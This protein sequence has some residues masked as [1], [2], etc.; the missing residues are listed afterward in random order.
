MSY[1][2]HITTVKISHYRLNEAHAADNE[3]KQNEKVGEFPPTILGVPVGR[4]QGELRVPEPVAGHHHPEDRQLVQQ[5]RWIYRFSKIKL[6][7]QKTHLSEQTQCGVKIGRA[8]PNNDQ[9]KPDHVNSCTN[10]NCTHMYTFMEL[11]DH[12]RS[13]SCSPCAGP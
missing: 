13:A 6:V 8:E 11:T 3:G 10:K 4:G 1:H 2:C 7:G 9:K 12:C 5:L